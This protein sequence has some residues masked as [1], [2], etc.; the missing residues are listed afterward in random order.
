MG[1]WRYSFSG[2]DVVSNICLPEWEAFAAEEQSGEPDVTISLNP[3]PADCANAVAEDEY[4]FFVEKVGRFYVRGGQEIVVSPLE[5]AS[6][7]RV[8]IFLLGSAWGAL[9]YQ[10]KTLII[11]ASAI[12]IEDGAVAFCAR[13]G[14]GKSTLAAS[15]AVLGHKLVSDDLCCLRFPDAGT[16]MVYPSV[17]RARLWT[18]AI[19]ELGLNTSNAEPD[20]LRPGKFQYFQQL[21]S[22]AGPLPLR[23]LYILAWGEVRIQRLTGFDSL[24]RF[25][26]ASQWRAD[27][28]LSAGSPAE[29]MRQCADLLQRV[30]VSEFRRP[31]DLSTLAESVRFLSYYWKNA[32]IR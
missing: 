18:D 5:S 21:T 15:L 32:L 26:S 22:S 28:L 10:R 4:R 3:E 6:I 20:P 7:R 17:P 2:L 25:L 14:D 29:Y 13:R 12:Q 31:R 9:L 23:A 19:H 8:R 11:H 30:P 16:P 27:L 1:H 24:Q